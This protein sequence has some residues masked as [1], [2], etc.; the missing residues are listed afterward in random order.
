MEKTLFPFVIPFTCL[1]YFIL[2]S[3]LASGSETKLSYVTR[4]LLESAREPE[5]FNWLKRVR[6]RIHEYP[7]LAFEEYNTSE[8]IRSELDSLGIK[9]IW[10]IA[11]TGG[12]GSVGSGLETWFGLRADMDALPIQVLSLGFIEAGQ[13]GNVIPEKVRFGG[14]IRSI[15][16]EGLSYLQQRIK[17]VVENQAAVHQCSASVDF[18]EETMRPYPATVN[19]EAMYE[20]AKQVGEALLGESNVQVAAP[21]MA[22]E[23]FSFYAQKMKAAFFQIGVQNKNEKSFK[24]LHTPFFFLDEEVLPIGA[25]L[26]AAVAISYLDNSAVETH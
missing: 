21:I 23:D 13:A 9:Y 20:H 22:A 15:T 14:T 8:V 12:V 2:L 26:H 25:A 4:E 1:S 18:M 5:F 3:A 10:P 19:D 7:E 11:K 16:T 24:R 6:R 17:E